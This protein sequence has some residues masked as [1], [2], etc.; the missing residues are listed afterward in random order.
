MLNRNLLNEA[1]V[2]Y[3]RRRS[4]HEVGR[5]SSLA[6]IYQR[7]AGSVPFTIGA[8]RVSDLYSRQV[9]FSDT[10]SWTHGKHDVRF[11]G[12][13]WPVTSQ[14]ASAA[15]PGTA[16]ARHVHVHRTRR[17]A[18]LPFDQLTL[19]D[20]QNY[21]QPINFG[22]PAAYDLNQWLGAG[23]RAGQHPRHAAT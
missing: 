5:A 8:V 22:Q 19:A 1:R 18:T 16:L 21:S 6:T 14:A 17:T 7:T 23:V 12:S 11:G 9:Q 10:L 13:I 15:S 2:A 20:V 4:G 3:T